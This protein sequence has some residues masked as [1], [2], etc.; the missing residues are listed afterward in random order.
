VGDIIRGRLKKNQPLPTL[1]CEENEEL[2]KSLLWEIGC[3]REFGEPEGGTKE[4][5]LVRR[6][7]E[8]LD[9]DDKLMGQQPLSTTEPKDKVRPR[10]SIPASYTTTKIIFKDVPT[11]LSNMLLL[12][13]TIGILVQNWATNNNLYFD[14]ADKYDLKTDSM[15]SMGLCFA[16]SC[17]VFLWSLFCRALEGVKNE[18]FW[19]VNA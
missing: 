16:G 13:I 11:S 9:N 15:L 12:A 4:Q 8:S 1:T 2:R 17:L 10:N 3:L 14:M 5:R 7:Q 18:V 19:V 6:V